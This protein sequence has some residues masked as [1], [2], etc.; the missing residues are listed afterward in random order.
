MSAQD[1]AAPDLKARRPLS[2][3]LQV[4]RPQLTSA[5][6][7]F[8]RIT[9]CALAVG[10]LLL[11]WWLVAAAAGPEAYAAASGFIGSWLGLLLLLGWS[12]A[13]FYHLANGIRH[14]V[15]DAGYGFELPTV[16]ASGWAVVVATGVLTLLAW[17]VGLA[18]W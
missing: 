3:H 13:L 8:H 6:S 18:A 11:V 2:P 9:G 4:Y 10:T 12:A 15:W 16:Y 17:I 7:I 14:L 5:L 1:E